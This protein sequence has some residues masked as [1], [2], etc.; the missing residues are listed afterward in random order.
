[1]ARVTPGAQAWSADGGPGPSGDVG[2]LLLHGFTGNPVSLRP[3][4]EDLAGR[5]FAVQLPRLP[6]HGTRWQDL[7]RTTWHDWV[8]E[9]AAGLRQLHST[10]RAQVL[11]GLSM[12]GA[13][14]LHLAQTRAA[15][16]AGL[17]LINPW[18]YSSDRRLKA[19]PLLKL[20]VP[21][22]PGVGN[23]ICK[24]GGDE[25]PYPKV[26]LKALASVLALQRQVRERLGEVLAPTLI[27]TSRHDH[28]V[29]PANSAL[30]LDSIGSF[31]SEQRWLERSYH[32]ATLD[33][34]APQI[35][36]ATADFA[37]RVAQLAAPHRDASAETGKAEP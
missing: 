32:V 24:P 27:L 21:A 12:G 28:I 17:L 1:M 31:D 20:A 14:A 25:K 34:D 7:Q 33:H 19:L 15:E 29:E 18:L 5:G 4:A 16:V 36:H 2:I 10:T 30:V 6:G 11:V 8:R 13:I 9:A 35:L 26:P 23:D 37:L 22:V 3:L